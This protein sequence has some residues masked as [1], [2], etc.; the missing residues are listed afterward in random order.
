M[1]NDVDLCGTTTPFGDLVRAARDQ[2]V[3]LRELEER[4]RD[5]ET[6]AVVGYTTF[7]RIAHDKGVMLTPQLVGAVARAVGR[8][9]RE[10]RL[11]AAQQYLGLI[12][13]DPLGASSE[14]ASVLVVHVPGATAE[15]LPRVQT[16]LAGWATGTGVTEAGN[17][18]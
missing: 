10:V 15:D 17:Q 8:P 9:D 13:G 1:S 7:H 14:E 12:V 2:G 3:S 6:G 4:S 11:A 18:D 5:P 16:L